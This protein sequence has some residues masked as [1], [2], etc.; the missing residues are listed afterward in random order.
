MYRRLVLFGLAV[1]GVAIIALMLPLALAARDAARVEEIAEVSAEAREV[2]DRWQTAYPA[3][4]GLESA[5]HP[6]TLVA[7]GG[8]VVLGSVPESAQVAVETA[9]NGSSAT[10]EADGSVISVVPVSL[11]G[12]TGAV[13]VQL[14]GDDIADHFL[15]RIIGLV[16]IGLTLFGFAALAAW[17]F[18]RQT[19]RP[20]SQLANTAE[21]LA[22]GDLGARAER[23]D[24]RELDEVATAL[25]RMAGRIQ[26]LLEAERSS[27][28]ELA[29]G[30]RTPLTVLSIDIDAVAD[31]ETRERLRSD[32]LE[33][34]SKTDEI[35]T[36][37][38]SA[39]RAGLRAVADVA[40]TARQRL[41][42]WSVLA[43]DQHR[44]VTAT[45]PEEPA[46]ARITVEDLTTLLDIL[47]QNIFTHTPEGT[48]FSLDVCNDQGAVRLQIR[49]QGPGLAA[50]TLTRE[51]PGSTGLGLSIA[52]QIAKGAGG[53]LTMRNMEPSGFL[54][55]VRLAEPLE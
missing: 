5:D 47:L 26:E 46:W 38:R 44:R 13:L 45:V 36:S 23:T 29:H 43:E 30:L 50:H 53:T 28:A 12:G 33:L 42:F 7:P 6:A 55:E 39:S 54:V 37:A 48:D 8:G 51:V 1:V 15:P 16:A 2:A 25:N 10:L 4:A 21:A 19:V 27:A 31:P 24:I 20:I 18:A 52:R 40:A 34:Q 9:L 22:E 14:S 49:D 41:Q 11:P 32:A 17:F 3:T 35:I